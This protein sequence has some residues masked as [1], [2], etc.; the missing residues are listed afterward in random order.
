MSNKGFNRYDH[1]VMSESLQLH[2]LYVA[3]QA[4]LSMEFCRQEYWSRLHS[5]LQ[6]N[7][8]DPGIESGSPAL[9][10]DSLTSE[11]PGK[12]NNKELYKLYQLQ[13]MDYMIPSN[14][15]IVGVYLLSW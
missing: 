7:L 13:S 11:P 5:L 9:Q 6:E 1:S 10:A 14:N 3:S 8:P 12:S 15:V 4:P 2:G